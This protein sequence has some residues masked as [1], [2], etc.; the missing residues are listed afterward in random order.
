MLLAAA[1]AALAGCAYGP[2]YATYGQGYGYP[3]Y[4]YGY[5]G[6]AY[7]TYPD[8]FYGGPTVS[9]VGNTTFDRRSRV[10]PAER[11]FGRG[12]GFGDIDRDGIPNN[13]D[14]DRDGDGVSNRFDTR[15]NNPRRR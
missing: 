3:G 4:G 10:A 12:G 13:A 6:P 14:P 5:P 7:A 11:R 15:P 2:G 9:I 8:Y 1:A